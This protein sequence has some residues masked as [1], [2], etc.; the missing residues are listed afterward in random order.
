MSSSRAITILS[1]LLPSRI[2]RPS[3]TL[4]MA[5]SECKSRKAWKTKLIFC[6]RSTVFSLPLSSFTATPSTNTVPSSGDSKQPSKDN[7][8]VFPL[9]EGPITSESVPRSKNCETPRSAR[10]CASR[11][12]NET[13]APSTPR[14]WLGTEHP[15]RLNCEGAS[16]GGNRRQRAHGQ[17]GQDHDQEQPPGRV[18]PGNQ[19][20]CIAN[21]GN[22]RQQPQNTAEHSANQGLCK[23]DARHEGLRR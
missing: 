5:E 10:T 6:R 18:N 4:S 17:T 7:K 13:L 1:A 11:L 2:S 14:K 12:P 9:P 3:A 23:N 22:D 16:N 8:V 19:R 15:P 21:A 20:F